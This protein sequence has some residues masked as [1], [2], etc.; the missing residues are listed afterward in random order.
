MSQ[1]QEIRIQLDG[2]SNVLKT[3][4]FRVPA[5]QRSY[6]WEREHVDALLGDIADAIKSRESEYF[7]GSIV[8]T[9]PEEARYEVV[10]G[11]QRL[12]TISLLIA[13]IKDIFADQGDDEVVA[14]VKTEFLSSTDR[15]TKEREPKLVLNEVDNE[16]YQELIDRIDKVDQSKFTR[17]SHKRL[18]DA[19]NAV[20]EYMRKVCDDSLDPEDDLHKWLDYLESNLKVIV[21]TAPDDSNAF[22]IFETL[23]DR[24]LE[25]ATSDLLKNYLFHRSGEKIEE[26]KNRWLSMVAVLESASDDPLVVTYLRHV[27]MSKYGVVREKDLF[28]LIKKKITSKKLAL[29]FS[30]E[31][32]DTARTYTALINTDHDFWSDF[33]PLVRGC[34]SAFNLLGM[35]Q[36]R[37]LLLAIIERFDK[38]QL[39][40]AFQKLEA[41]AVRFQV[42]G[43]GGGGSLERIYSD[44]AKLVT[45]GKLLNAAGII[46]AFPT[47]PVDSTFVQ[48]FGLLTVSKQSLA[49]YYLRNLERVAA[50]GDGEL[51]PNPDTGRV[52]LEHVLPLTLTP[53]WER[54][55]SPE[56]ARSYQRRLGNMAL[57]SAKGNSIAGNDSFAAKQ[58]KYRTSA[59]VLT[60]S[61][62]TYRKW[63]SAEIDARQAE[64]ATYAAKAWPIK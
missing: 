56:D 61:L 39:T 47:L 8:V 55:W 43:G 30:T 63:T 7:L 23:N 16:L 35:T 10:D 2:V 29:A 14:S 40:L 36:M 4:R 54:D 26:T 64:M 62:A 58:P 51:V 53:E 50:A 13:A 44:T 60:K 21:V 11:Q 19:A 42:V 59:F 22:V 45:E 37:P 46:R 49:R 17:Q 9:G 52:N 28:G 18:I 34:V 12:T 25:L 38:K 6:A 27:A 31:L 33:D 15:R 3:R 57:M 5:Y 24:G 32:R 41:V 48:S 20:L 1:V